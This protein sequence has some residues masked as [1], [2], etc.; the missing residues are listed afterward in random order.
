MPFRR[1]L[2]HGTLHSGGFRFKGKFRFGC[3]DVCIYATC[4]AFSPTRTWTLCVLCVVSALNSTQ[5]K[6]RKPDI[7]IEKVCRFWAVALA[8][9]IAVCDGV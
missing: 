4:P 8:C 2:E 1:I 3:N 7:R 5:S 6:L 9:C